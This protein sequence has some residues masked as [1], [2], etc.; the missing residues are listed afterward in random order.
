MKTGKEL[1]GA[2]CWVWDREGDP[3]TAVI[4]TDYKEGKLRPF[5]QSNLV[6][7]KHA[8]AKTPAEIQGYMSKAIQLEREAWAR[9]NGC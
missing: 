6:T 2:W 7:W 4:I 3:I 8:R 5:V 9:L 1:I